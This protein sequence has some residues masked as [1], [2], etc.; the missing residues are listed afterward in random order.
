MPDRMAAW[1]VMAHH[2][3]YDHSHW[4]ADYGLTLYDETGKPI[5]RMSILV[6][7]EQ[8][9]FTDPF[10]FA[11]TISHRP[12]LEGVTSVD[13]LTF[14][15]DFSDLP[16]LEEETRGPEY[17]EALRFFNIKG[18]CRVETPADGS[19][20]YRFL[21]DTIEGSGKGEFARIKGKGVMRVNFLSEEKRDKAIDKTVG[22][23]LGVGTCYWYEMNEA[24]KPLC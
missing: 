23:R 14:T 12:E 13:P 6:P 16:V 1:H 15:G 5:K 20:N 18:S 10:S 3:R 11:G 24:G 9:N 7:Y 19:Y 21:F 17:Y 22:G 2:R 4:S 8:E